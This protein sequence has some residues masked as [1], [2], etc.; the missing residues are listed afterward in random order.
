[1]RGR[2]IGGSGRGSLACGLAVLLPCQSSRTAMRVHSRGTQRTLPTGHTPL[3]TEPSRLPDS[4]CIPSQPSTY[5][6][7][8][9]IRQYAQRSRQTPSTTPTKASTTYAGASKRQVMASS[10]SAWHFLWQMALQPRHL[11]PCLL[12]PHRSLPHTSQNVG[13]EGGRGI[14]S[15]SQAPRSDL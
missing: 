7:A 9:I 2:F 10:A 1:M 13:L 11:T 12:M 3:C 14:V 4:M 15:T 6:G 8:S 5:S